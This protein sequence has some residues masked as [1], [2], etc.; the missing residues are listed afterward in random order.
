[1]N[2]VTDGRAAGMP[3]TSPLSMRTGPD[4]SLVELG[5]DDPATVAWA[6]VPAAVTVATAAAEASDASRNVRRPNPVALWV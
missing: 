5:R 3:E 2:T 4:I 6:F 1:M